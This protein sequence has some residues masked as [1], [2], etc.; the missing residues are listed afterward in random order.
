MGRL[1]ILLRTA[2]PF[3]SNSIP[4]LRITRIGTQPTR[5]VAGLRRRR[6]L[7]ELI[8]TFEGAKCALSELTRLGFARTTMIGTN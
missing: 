2:I 6:A 8:A 3:A 5:H 1:S 7:I 4:D